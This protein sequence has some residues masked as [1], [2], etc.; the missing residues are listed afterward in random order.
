[1]HQSVCVVN[2]RP[3]HYLLCAFVCLLSTLFMLSLYYVLIFKGEKETR[4]MMLSQNRIADRSQNG[5]VHVARL[6]NR[7]IA[8]LLKPLNDA[9]C[10]IYLVL[11]PPGQG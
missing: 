5:I 7:V 8:T 11:C 9:S 1:M 10:N 6:L 4:L 2:F 3:R